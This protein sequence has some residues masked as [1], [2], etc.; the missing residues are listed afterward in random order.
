[1][2]TIPVL[3]LDD[4]KIV[5]ESVEALEFAVDFWDLVEKWKSLWYSVSLSMDNKEDRFILFNKESEK[6]KS[7]L[8]AI[9][10]LGL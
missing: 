1:M 6:Y 9:E 8:A 3:H 4:Y 2:W 7:L 5:I 10:D